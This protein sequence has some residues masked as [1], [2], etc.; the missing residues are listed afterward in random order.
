M[1]PQL[2]PR[3]A[4]R[5][6]G[7]YHCQRLGSNRVVDRGLRVD[8]GPADRGARESRGI[9]RLVLFPAVRFGR[10]LRLASSVRRTTAGGSS[11]P[12]PTCARRPGATDTTRSCWRPCYETDRG[13]V[14]A[15]DFMP[16]RG[17]APDIVR[18][19]EGLSGLRS[20]A[21]RAGD[22]FDHGRIVPWVRR[23]D[24][25]LVA[26][27]G[28]DA[29][30]LWSPIDTHGE[31]MT[32]VAEFTLAE[33]ERL[34]FVLT[35]F[36]SHEPLP[37]AGRRRA[38]AR[39]DRGVLA[40]LG[41]RRCTSAGDYHEEINESLV[42][43][44]AMTYAPTG[45]IVA[46]PTTSLPEALGG[47]RNWDY[48]FC[49]LRDATLTLL[50]MLKAGSRGEAETWSQ[51]L[52]ARRRRGPRGHPGDVRAR[53]GASPGRA[54]AG[55]A[56]GLRG[57]DAGPDRER[58]IDA[59]PAGRLRRDPRRASISRGSRALRRMRTSGR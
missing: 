11:H 39:R 17:H 24:D 22:P 30:C 56:A 58:G 42:V 7:R 29:L 44:K 10:V 4:G 53:R 9:D 31:D 33:G 15:I 1:G 8:R 23:M 35:W 48:R 38:C 5:P 20:D 50:A 18:I 6:A 51:W 54:R 49:W 37:D 32:T 26:V 27:A 36:P 13:A 34:A 55:L 25:A 46:A 40:G 57:L 43:L 45:G 52:L 2:W 59:A 41:R 3:F 19:V 14:R 12:R 21:V 47:E 16:P 28:P